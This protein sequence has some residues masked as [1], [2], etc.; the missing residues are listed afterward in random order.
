MQSWVYS[1]VKAIYGTSTPRARWRTCASYVNTYYGLSLGRLFVK[2]AF[3]E[4]A[5]KEV[6]MFINVY[7]SRCF[8]CLVILLLF[9]AYVKPWSNCTFRRWIWST[10]WEQPLGS[11]STRTPGWTTQHGV[12][13]RRR[14]S[15]LLR[16]RAVFLTSSQNHLDWSYNVKIWNCVLMHLTGKIH[17]GE[18]WIPR[19]HPEFNSSGRVLWKC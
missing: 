18:N 16:S 8:F 17:S 10:I 11:L 13:P 12:S 9:E 4:E 5:K 19:L 2:E 3:D 14:F 1:L 15:D 6:I 7:P